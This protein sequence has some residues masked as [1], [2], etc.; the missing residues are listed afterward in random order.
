MSD[1]EFRHRKT[2]LWV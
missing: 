2:Y 1:L